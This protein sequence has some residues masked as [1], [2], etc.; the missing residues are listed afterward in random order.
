MQATGAQAEMRRTMKLR[1]QDKAGLHLL[2]EVKS[3]G[4]AVPFMSA[5]YVKSFPN[6]Q[7]LS[8]R[9]GIRHE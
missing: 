8:K 9:R 5:C 7:A 1:H 3:V 4:K 6:R 2:D